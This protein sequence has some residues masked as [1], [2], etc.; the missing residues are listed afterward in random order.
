MTTA[1]QRERIQHGRARGGIRTAGSTAAAFTLV[2]LL[3]VMAISIIILGLLFG[4]LVQGFNLTRR[5]QAITQAQDAIRFGLENLIRELSEAAFVYDNSSTPIILPLEDPADLRRD[6]TYPANPSGLPPSTPPFLYAK[7]DFA[8]AR[9]RTP[10]PVASSVARRSG[11]RCRR[12]GGSF[13]TSSACAGTSAWR[14]AAWSARSTT[15]TSTSSRAATTAST[16]RSSCTGP[17]STPPTR[18]WS[19]RTRR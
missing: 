5:T 3:I 4:P 9:S 1:A 13:A 8:P 11:S 10:R 19:T 16:T 18:T 7:L 12:A 14:R 6:I 2:E 17:S 15:T